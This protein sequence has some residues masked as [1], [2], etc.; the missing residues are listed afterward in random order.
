MVP[1]HTR[2]PKIDSSHALYY[3]DYDLH[4]EDAA[5]LTVT[6]AFP[7][8]RHNRLLAFRELECPSL[9]RF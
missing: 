9:L 2:Q 7:L 3:W 8:D 1:W 4:N 5:P 6:S